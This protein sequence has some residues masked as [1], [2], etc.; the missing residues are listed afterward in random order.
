MLI[1]ALVLDLLVLAVFIEAKLFKFISPL[2]QGKDVT[3]YVLANVYTVELLFPAM[4]VVSGSD[5][6]YDHLRG[7][8]RHFDH[9]M[10]IFQWPFRGTPFKH[11][12]KAIAA[13]VKLCTWWSLTPIVFFHNAYGGAT[14]AAHLIEFTPAFGLVVSEFVVCPPTQRCPYSAT[15]LEAVGFQP[16]QVLSPTS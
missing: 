7:Q 3:V 9:L 13:S 5:R 14:D 10:W 16:C 2:L 4:V 12:R 15:F 8:L 6:F 1:V 11:W